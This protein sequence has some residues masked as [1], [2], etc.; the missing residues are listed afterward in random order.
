MSCDHCISVLFNESGVHIF[1]FLNDVVVR[2]DLLHRH[3]VLLQNLNNQSEPTI[4]TA[5]QHSATA[6]RSTAA[7]NRM[8]RI[9]RSG[10]E[11]TDLIDGALLSTKADAEGR[12]KR[13]VSTQPARKRV[14]SGTGEGGRRG[15]DAL[16]CVRA[17]SVVP[18]RIHRAKEHTCKPANDKKHS[19]AGSQ[20]QIKE[21][22]HCCET[23][24]SVHSP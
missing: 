24:C 16:R 2:K 19:T 6:Q 14:R 1:A 21:Q 3:R 15:S 23:Q 11:R 10:A 17:S 13:S 4:S 8:Q 20:N 22:S 12:P 9:A 7:A 18:L 5:L